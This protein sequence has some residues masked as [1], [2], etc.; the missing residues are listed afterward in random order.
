MKYACKIELPNFA[1]SFIS[2]GPKLAT[3][4]DIFDIH[5]AVN[6]EK[7][8]EFFPKELADKKT[9]IHMVNVNFDR[10][11]DEVAIHK[12]VKEKCVINIYFKTNNE[13]TIFYQGQ[14]VELVPDA[15][16]RSFFKKLS[17]NS[18]QKA[19]SFV[20]HDNEC[21]LLNTTQPH[22]VYSNQKTGTRTFLQIY[23]FEDTYE[24]IAEILG[25]KHGCH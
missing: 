1:E 2:A 17:P 24:E 6:R 19:E 8:V 14:E 20:A 12:H 13:E 15:G 9:T 4:V 10:G 7:V 18:L 3:Y 16:K 25:A 23:F 22:S 21:W 11:L 5:K